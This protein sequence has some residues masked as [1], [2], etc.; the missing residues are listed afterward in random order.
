MP[1]LS[2]PSVSI[3]RGSLVIDLRMQDGIPTMHSIFTVI[4]I[5]KLRT[6]I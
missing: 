2:R 5:T 6:A 1:V 3:A 4:I